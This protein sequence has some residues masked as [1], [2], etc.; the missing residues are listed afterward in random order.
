MNPHFSCECCNIQEIN[1]ASEEQNIY[2]Y[3]RTGMGRC[4]RFHFLREPWI[5]DRHTW[6][7]AKLRTNRNVFS[8]RNSSITHALVFCKT[9]YIPTALNPQ[10]KRFVQPHSRYRNHKTAYLVKIEGVDVRGQGLCD[11]T[12]VVVVRCVREIYSG[13]VVSCCCCAAGEH[14]CFGSVSFAPGAV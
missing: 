10:G 14:D 5:I 4:L 1:N 6:D 8:P 12:V 9:R 7:A 3:N 11:I 2:W 13:K